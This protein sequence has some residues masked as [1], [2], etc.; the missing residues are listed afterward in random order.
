[1]TQDE[2]V[3]VKSAVIAV[4]IEEF[5][6]RGCCVSDGSYAAMFG[7]ILAAI[8]KDH[9]IMLR[10]LDEGMLH[11]SHKS[12]GAHLPVIRAVHTA[13]IAHIEGAKS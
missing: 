9:V 5:A 11:A 6:A 8:S 10:V 7:Q 12:T 1:M 2:M 13:L 4:L 3:E